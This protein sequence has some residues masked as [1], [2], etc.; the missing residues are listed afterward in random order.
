VEPP[1]SDDLEPDSAP[2]LRAT[3]VGDRLVLNDWWP[4][5]AGGGPWRESFRL[6]RD[7]GVAIA[8]LHR[9]RDARGDGDLVV[10]FLSGGDRERAEAVLER[11]ARLAGYRRIWFD[12]RLADLGA[13]PPD[14]PTASVTCT[15]C[16]AGWDDGKPEFWKHVRQ[17]GC[18]PRTCMLC[19]GELPQW[20]VGEEDDPAGRAAGENEPARSF[21]RASE[22]S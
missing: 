3:I 2:D 6:R 19:G 15:T 14:L 12:D 4:G 1:I 22:P 8:D 7:A 9:W 10:E 21:T 17:A 18:F 11:W 20:E 13:E 5:L 16:G